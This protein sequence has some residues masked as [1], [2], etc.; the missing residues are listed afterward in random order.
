MQ[1]R[2]RDEN[3]NPFINILQWEEKNKGMAEI[4]WFF[5]RIAILFFSQCSMRQLQKSVPP[6]GTGKLFV[7]STVNLQL[8]LTRETGSAWSPSYRNV[9]GSYVK[10]LGNECDW[11]KI[12][13][14]LYFLLLCFLPKE[15]FTYE[16]HKGDKLPFWGRF[17]AGEAK[18]K[19]RAQ[20]TGKNFFSDQ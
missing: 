7:T 20:L 1:R 9:C 12:N 2:N 19:W 13:S 6:T 14:C 15:Q 8:A 16:L 11:S 5:L 3:N 18:V 17:T 10:S 4:W